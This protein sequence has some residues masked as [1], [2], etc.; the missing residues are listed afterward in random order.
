MLPDKAA[1]LLWPG[2]ASGLLFKTTDPGW[3]S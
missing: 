2:R 1:S 3:D